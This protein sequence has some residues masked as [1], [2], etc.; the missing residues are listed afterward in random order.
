MAVRQSVPVPCSQAV[1][2]G[3]VIDALGGM[4]TPN[5]VQKYTPS[6]RLMVYCLRVRPACLDKMSHAPLNHFN[7]QCLLLFLIHP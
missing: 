7:N 1:F 6:L 5:F 2:R 4:G 3:L